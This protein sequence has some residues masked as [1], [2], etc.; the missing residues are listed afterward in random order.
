MSIRKPLA[1]LGTPISSAV[2]HLPA[3]G[4]GAMPWT[5]IGTLSALGIG[6]AGYGF[7]RWRKRGI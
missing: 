4:T 1:A 2:A 6:G 5:T 7:W 3:E